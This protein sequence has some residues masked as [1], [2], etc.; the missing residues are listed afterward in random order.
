MLVVYY[1]AMF[2]PVCSHIICWIHGTSLSN[3]YG[4]DR[5]DCGNLCDHV[6]M[7]CISI[8]VYGYC[9]WSVFNTLLL[10][11]LSVSNHEQTSIV[12]VI[13]QSTRRNKATI[14]LNPF[15]IVI[16]FIGWFLCWHLATPLSDKTSMKVSC[17]LLHILKANNRELHSAVDW[18]E[19]R[20]AWG[21]TLCF[22]L[23]K[24]PYPWWWK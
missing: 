18:F 3:R 21:C 12:N 15:F 4:A 19:N 6:K 17:V 20:K 5:W 11:L 22:L 16:S 13:K 10:F 9:L 1:W 14:I 24:I 23:N 7:L 8:H 2:I